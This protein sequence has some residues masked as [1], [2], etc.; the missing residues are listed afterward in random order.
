MERHT[1]TAD[2]A[3]K[4]GERHW[5]WEVNRFMRDVRKKHEGIDYADS[6]R[7]NTALDAEVK[8]LANKPENADKPG[9]WFLREAHK[10][11][12]ASSSSATSRRR[13]RRTRGR[14]GE[15]RGE[16]KRESRR[17][18]RPGERQGADGQ[19][20]EDARRPA[21]GRRRRSRQGRRGRIRR[22]QR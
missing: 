3:E 11:V 2:L 5:Q 1:V 14:R 15:G 18:K 10:K 9:R 13:R 7:L 4:A 12:K 16:A 17:A 22:G 19:A 6:I 21:G 20:A 8:A